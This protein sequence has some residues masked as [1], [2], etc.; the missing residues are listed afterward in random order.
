M[1]VAVATLPCGL[2]TLLDRVRLMLDVV[3]TSG[4]MITLTLLAIPNAYAPLAV[5]GVALPAG[6]GMLGDA[7]VLAAPS[8]Y[9]CVAR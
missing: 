2:K 8:P 4:A 1:F 5:G 3:I 6:I 9:G 7:M